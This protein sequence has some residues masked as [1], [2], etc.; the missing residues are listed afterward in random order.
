MLYR[1]RII[2]AVLLAVAALSHPG[3]SSA[4]EHEELGRVLKIMPPNGP[5]DRYGNVV[6]RKL[7]K[8][9][10]MPAVVFPH[11]S[12]RARYTCRVCHVDL[13]F[14]MRAG[15]SGIS[16]DSCQSGKFCGVCHNGKTAFAAMGNGQTKQ[17]ERCHMKDAKRLAEPFRLFAAGLPPAS[18]GNKIDWAQAL[19]QGKI[20]PK[21]S[22]V[23]GTPVEP[24]PTHLRKPL[25]LSTPAP[26]STV[27]FSH[28]DHNAEMDCTICHPDIFNIKKKGTVLFSMETNLYGQFCG[29]CHMR[30]AFPMNDCRRCHPSMNYTE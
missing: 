24:L 23:P 3:V 16:K 5:A 9:A 21:S 27:T 22:L 7:S 29:A 30:V 20:T 4:V 13:E 26:R 28:E 6:M 8:Q 17:C 15:A 10:G 2:V 1:T 19:A 25:N 18:Y 14:A 12:H 11:W